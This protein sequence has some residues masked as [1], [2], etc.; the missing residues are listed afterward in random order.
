MEEARRDMREGAARIG[1]G[2]MYRALHPRFRPRDDRDRT[3]LDRRRNEILA[4]EFFADEGAENRAGRDLAM[5]DR[6]PRHP[7][8]AALQRLILDKPDEPHQFVS[9]PR[10]P[11]GRGSATP[12]SRL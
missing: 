6:E 10:P 4:V 1:I 5:V 3:R 11:S 2:D 8:T 7:G 12:Q 9:T